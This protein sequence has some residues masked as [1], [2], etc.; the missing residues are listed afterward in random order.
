M[1]TAGGIDQLRVHADLVAHPP[2]TAFDNV[3]N[4]ELTT[5]PLY[6]N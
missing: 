2:D 3:A 4:T 6:V 5:D 1:G